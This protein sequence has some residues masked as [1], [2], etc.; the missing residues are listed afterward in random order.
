MFL[1]P[2]FHGLFL[3]GWVFIMCVDLV[4]TSSAAP[5]DDAEAITRG[6][7]SQEMAR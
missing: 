6:K 7:K 3:F 4:M 1:S 2:F 5:A